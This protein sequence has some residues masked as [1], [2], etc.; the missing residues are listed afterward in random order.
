MGMW[1]L[2]T[3]PVHCGCSFHAADSAAAALPALKA[4][5]SPAHYLRAVFGLALIDSATQ[6]VL[7]LALRVAAPGDRTAADINAL[8][9]SHA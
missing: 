1:Q 5:L 7:G 8:L 9:G 2:L 6:T 4:C 3:L